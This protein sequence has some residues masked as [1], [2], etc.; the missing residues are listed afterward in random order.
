MPRLASTSFLL[1]AVTSAAACGREEPATNHGLVDTTRPPVAAPSPVVDI[2][3]IANKTEAEVAT[4]LG[5]PT[6]QDTIRNNG[7]RYPKRIYRNGD[8]DIVFVDGRADW[9]TVFGQGR[10]PYG[11]GVLAALGLPYRTPT[12]ENPPAVIRW[13]NI[14]G[15]HEVSVF[16]GKNGRAYYA[17]VL[18]NTEP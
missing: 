8:I 2:P 3:S 4:V 5:Q 10:L 13:S 12:F 9:I 6:G 17:Y 11:T 15:I 16:P 14:R 18:I 1:A 7:K